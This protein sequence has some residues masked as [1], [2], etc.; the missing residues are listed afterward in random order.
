M[1]INRREF[2]GAAAIAASA[3]LEKFVEPSAYAL[4]TSVD[5][6]EWVQSGLIDAGGWHEPYIFLVRRGGQRLDTH[7]IT[8]KDQ[9]EELIK[10]LHDQG[11]DVFHTHLYKGFGMAAEKE[12]MEETRK[13]AAIAHRYGMKVDTYVQWNTM[14]YE[15][16]FAEEPRAKDWI[17]RDISGLPIL[18]TYGYQQ[19]WRYRPCFANQEYLDYL[20]KVVHYAVFEVKSDFLHFDNF[21][22]NA[23][24]DS[25][26]CRWCTDGFRKRLREKY[27]DEQRRERFGFANTDFVNPPQWNRDNPPQE[28]EIIFDP[29]Y[30]EWI[31]FRCQL[32]A[33]A[34]QQI[35]TYVK[36]LNPEV[37]VEI[38]CGGI[39]GANRSWEAGIDHARL[40]KHTEVMVSEENNDKAPYY[41]S[42]GHL[43]TKIRSFK[44]TR[45]YKNILKVPSWVNSVA[46]AEA[47]A[48]S[49]TLGSVGKSPLS[50]EM[51]RYISF[52]RNHRELY[53]GSDEVAPVAVFRSYASLTNNNAH[54]QLS[55]ILVE[56][57]LIQSGLPFTLIFDE[58]L[59]D[60]SKYKVAIL[61][62]TECLS[63]VQI[64]LIRRYVDAGGG[65]IVTEQAGLYDEWR[66]VRTAPG[67]VGLVD[68][69]PMAS[70]YQERVEDA[71]PAA[72][73]SISRKHL[74]AGRVA[75]IPSVDFDGVL[76][77]HDKYFAITKKFWKRPKN[78][79]DIVDAVR[80]AAGDRLNFSIEGPDFLVANYTVQP[81]KGIFLVH[82]VN[83]NAPEVP[84]LSNIPARVQLPGNMTP[85]KVTLY[86]P[87][88]PEGQSLQFTTDA[89]GTS[90]TVTQMLSYALIAVR[91]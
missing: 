31:D 56:Q 81:K 61:P 16:F 64:G 75:Y 58:H 1:E 60:L 79:K 91:S 30:Q 11:I 55:A 42:D 50:P 26:H 38:N 13:A 12:G 44:L 23:E 28:M 53:E 22:L 77:P 15:T 68:N 90:F 2:I 65:L 34:L 78:A 5:Q 39:T 47:L 59:R 82:L 72:L 84:T 89:A 29:G 51:L 67:L 48:F 76:P 57:A 80:W 18:L 6:G 25:C 4:P 87:E 73:G 21:D 32:M 85:A 43:V 24:P 86:T 70:A 69:Q 49:Q 83:Y 8:E 66:R 37:V 88:A 40:L 7:E 62:N 20:K 46:M 36:S 33:D 45:R 54:C 52:Y 74:G 71:G 27:T 14:M 10:K 17:Q 9:S 41:S 3:S 19:S 35:S 63:D